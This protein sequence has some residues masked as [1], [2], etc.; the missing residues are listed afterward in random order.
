MWFDVAIVALL[1]F[2]IVEGFRRGFVH[3][4][5]HTAGWILAVVLGF[6]W[7]PHALDY[8][9]NQTGI[10]NSINGKITARITEDA[11]SASN[12]ALSNI[13]EVIRGILEKAID[14]ATDA[15]ALTLSD[16]LSRLV[17]NILAFLLVVLAIKLILLFI[18]TLLSKK[19]NSGILG[20]IDGFLG[21]LSGA[22]KGI[23]LVY[24]LLALI[25]PVT[26]LWGNTILIDELNKST[27]GLYL[28]DN[29][30]IL[31]AVRDFL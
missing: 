14:S 24:I 9:K 3:T 31:W 16:S 4:F 25:V 7:Y 11:G 29:N 5:I 30:L 26:S 13:P 10:Y 2:T 6:V 17:F 8:L 19:K 20:G 1:I 21:I 27:I 22:L 18:T 15:I 12:A 28:Y 23:V